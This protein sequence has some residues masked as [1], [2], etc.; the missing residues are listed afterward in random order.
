M[1]KVIFHCLVWEYL[2][3]ALAQANFAT[4][5][6]FTD[7]PQLCYSDNYLINNNLKHIW[8]GINYEYIHQKILF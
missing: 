2:S 7:Q 4:W 6:E 5:A 1:F 8:K 3:V